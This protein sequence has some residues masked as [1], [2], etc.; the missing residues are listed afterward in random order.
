[1]TARSALLSPYVDP[2]S[3]PPD[4]L[5][6]LG[7]H[8][9]DRLVDRWEQLDSQPPIAPVD[10]AFDQRAIPPCPDG[11]TDPEEA[12]DQLFEESSRAASAPTTRASSPASAARATRSPSSPT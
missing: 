1:M 3:L 4:E 10:P 6:R 9:W 12:I 5:R 11:P 2:L 7:H 8:V